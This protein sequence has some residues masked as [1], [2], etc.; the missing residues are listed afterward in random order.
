VRGIKLHNIL[1]LFLLVGV[2]AG[3]SPIYSQGKLKIYILAGESNMTGQ[4]K[5]TPSSA[6]STKNGGMGTLDYLVLTD[7]TNT[8]SHLVTSG[9][10]Y[11]LRDDAWIYYKRNGTTEVKG[12]LTTGYGSQSTQIGPELQFGHAMGDF[13]GEQIL[14][15]KT[16]W[17]G[18][19]LGE[20]FY[21]PSSGDPSGYTTPPLTPADSGYYF[22]ETVS[23]VR[24]VINNLG[25]YFPSYDGN[26]YEIAGF[27]WH[28][29]W[30]DVIQPNLVPLYETNLKNF[31]LDMR[32]SLGVD[33][34]P[35][36]VGLGGLHGPYEN[37]KGKDYEDRVMEFWN[38]QFSVSD[39]VKNPGFIGN[40][41]T[42]DTRYFARLQENSVSNQEYFWHQNA[43]SFFL[44][45]DA[46][47]RGMQSLLQSDP[48]CNK[49]IQAEDAVFGGGATVETT[50][51]GYFGTGYVNFPP[52]GGFVE[53]TVEACKAGI[54]TLQ[55]RHALDT[56]NST[57]TLIVNSVRQPITT[58]TT[59]GWIS[60]KTESIAVNLNAG[61]NTIRFES[62][63]NDF[64]NLDQIKIE[65]AT[66]SNEINLGT[67]HDA[68]GSADLTPTF[69]WYSKGNGILSHTLYVGTSLDV[70]NSGTSYN[71][72][73]A[74]SH[75]L[76]SNLS[77]TLMGGT[78][79][80]WGV[81]LTDDNGTTKSV[82]RMFMPCNPNQG[83]TIK[84]AHQIGENV[85]LVHDV[86]PADIDGDGDMDVVTA[87]TVER[88]LLWHEN[89]GNQNFT[90][91]EI[92]TDLSGL[93]SVHAVDM[94]SD[95]DMDIL[96]AKYAGSRQVLWYENDGN[97][98][99][100]ERVI[101]SD[102]SIWVNC[103]HAA[104][105]DGDGDM[106][107]LSTQEGEKAAIW[108]ENDGSQNFTEHVIATGLNGIISIYAVDVDQDGDADV[109]TTGGEQIRWHKNDG[110]QNFATYV[111]P[112]FVFGS[113]NAHV[114][115]LDQDGDMDFLSVGSTDSQVV[116]YENDGSENFSIKEVAGSLSGAH[117]VFAADMD[118][119]QDMDVLVA[120]GSDSRIMW[121]ENDGNQN[122]SA[123]IVRDEG[124]GIIPIHAADM[125]GDGDLDIL[126]Y[127]NYQVLWF[128][129]E[130]IP[131]KDTSTV[132]VDTTIT[133]NIDTGYIT[134]VTIGDQIVTLTWTVILD[135]QD[136]IHVRSVHDDMNESGTYLVVLNLHTPDTF[137]VSDILTLH[138]DVSTEEEILK[139][140]SL[141][142]YPNPAHDQVTIEGEFKQWILTDALGAFIKGGTDKVIDVRGLSIGLYYLRVNEVVW[143]IIKI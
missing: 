141:V 30:N 104:D 75:T 9:V 74:T 82:V 89:D 10:N 22:M 115:D 14:I 48:T 110:N 1:F 69:T 50:A 116:W 76:P 137:T 135:N 64:G 26:G 105:M 118:G 111:L 52:T 31:I 4:G 19:S 80:Y 13:H 66:N 58:T 63:G 132:A 100:T 16:A 96:A 125:D 8:Y 33:N 129:N 102:P 85:G 127:D 56:L 37:I 6:D 27:G 95:G 106:D 21:P 25:T 91:H 17:D 45:G 73:K 38:A 126:S 41:T 86:F 54:S 109:V 36:V 39:Y 121:C 44:I 35:F 81:E 55:Y 15:I 62:T 51:K 29:G 34:L 18:L 134:K 97:Q 12:D 101:K 120:N 88:T 107:V 60:Y 11:K 87:S 68:T 57:G 108:H 79:Y 142:V 112:D 99:F 138:Y 131:I 119:D 7:T 72:N 20:N 130:G 53:F 123:S 46:M 124:Y 28:Q 2:S 93:L 103:I 139:N 42:A 78:I 61:T 49:T 24:D 94:D 32:D 23:I 67:P 117:D 136:T 83:D 43:E 143:K 40:V 47:A 140:T 5:I 70:F 92:N 65:L 122:F 98:N 59:E 71:V 84:T 114:A 128:E 113:F 90:A 77:S 133:A 3:F